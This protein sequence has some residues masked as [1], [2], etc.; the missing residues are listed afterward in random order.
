M[1]DG[2]G[3]LDGELWIRNNAQ[4]GNAAHGRSTSDILGLV[5]PFK[6]FEVG[7]MGVKEFDSPDLAFWTFLPVAMSIEYDLPSNGIINNVH[8]D[9]SSIRRQYV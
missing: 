5:H 1:S 3:S 6:L 2:T 7:C 8:F 4:N 9:M